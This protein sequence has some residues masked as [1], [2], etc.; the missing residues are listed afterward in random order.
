[1]AQSLEH[2]LLID[3]TKFNQTSLM[4][5]SQLKDFDLIITDELPGSD[6][7]EHFKT[8]KDYF[9]DCGIRYMMA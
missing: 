8:H 9:G 6:Y 2:I 7:I 5:Y 4:T 1:M 3:H